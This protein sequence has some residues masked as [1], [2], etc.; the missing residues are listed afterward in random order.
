MWKN[1]LKTI[2]AGLLA[3]PLV[4]VAPAVVSAQGNEN[5]GKKVTICH[6]TGSENN[7]YV[8]ESPNA[9]GDVSGH[10]GQSHQGGRDII[11]PFTYNEGDEE[12]SFPG[13]NWDANGQATF[14]NNCVPTTGGQGGGNPGGEV[15]G[16]SDTA[17]GQG[18]G[19][20]AAAGAVN[21]GFGGATSAAP[22]GAIIGIGTSLLSIASGLALFNRRKV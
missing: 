21:A 20:Q 12:K 4:V 3:T 18:A 14:N 13:Q 2:V 1:K 9:N 15:L 11:P 6:A 19:A 5:P 8:K 10:A 7:P 17:G 22:V 16:S